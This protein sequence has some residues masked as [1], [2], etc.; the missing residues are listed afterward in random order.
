MDVFQDG[1]LDETFEVASIRRCER[2]GEVSVVLECVY[3][4]EVGLNSRAD[5]SAELGENVEAA[6]VH[7]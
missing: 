7:V 1:I 4:H 3:I 5:L 2:A 6:I